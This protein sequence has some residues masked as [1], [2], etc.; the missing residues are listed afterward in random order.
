MAEVLLSPRTTLAG[1]TL[2]DL[3]F[4]DHY[5]LSVLAIWRKGHAYRQGL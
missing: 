3:L 4:R 5:G 1:R 2:N